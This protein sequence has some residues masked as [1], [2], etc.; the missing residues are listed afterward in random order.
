MVEISVAESHQRL[1][2]VVKVFFGCL[3]V[4]VIF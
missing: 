3:Y 2:T 1:D 4:L